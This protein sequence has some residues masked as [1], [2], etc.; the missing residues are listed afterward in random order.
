MDY[1]TTTLR[2]M[3]AAPLIDADT[4]DARLN[5]VDAIWTD[6]VD[7]VC[8][9]CERT[10]ERTHT[11]RACNSEGAPCPLKNAVAAFLKVLEDG[12]NAL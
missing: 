2:P 11:R 6:A 5:A 1:D 10:C 7:R 9:D 12:K 4:L 3:N 8:T